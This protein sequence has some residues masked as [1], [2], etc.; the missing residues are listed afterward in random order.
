MYWCVEKKR[1]FRESL[2]PN[3][4]VSLARLAPANTTGS[5]AFGQAIEPAAG[6]SGRS[7]LGDLGSGC[8]ALLRGRQ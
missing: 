1:P 2:S 7:G 5:T 8:G 4:S 6:A 3:R